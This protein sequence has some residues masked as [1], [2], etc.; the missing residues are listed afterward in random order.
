MMLFGY[1]MPVVQ[2]VG[3]AASQAG[4]GFLGSTSD[5]I[6]DGIPARRARLQWMA[7]A[8]GLGDHMRL[9]I[10]L[11][12]APVQLRIICVLGLTLPAGVRVDVDLVNG[13]AGL[14]VVA[15]LSAR[16]VRF[17]DGTVGAW[18]VFPDTVAP[19]NRVD[20]VLFND[21]SGAASIA[22]GAVFEIGEVAAMPAIDIEIERDWG[23]ERIDPTESELSR[24]SQPLS[25]GRQSYRRYEVT[26]VADA[27][28][29]VRGGGLAGGMD[30]NR[31][32]SSCGADARVIAVPRWRT[33]SG[34]V[35]PTALHA[36]ALYGTARFGRVSHLGGDYY[37]APV[38]FQEA[39]AIR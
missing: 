11:G 1:S 35:D 15:T 4:G 10:M 27:A 28:S 21:V 33:P 29:A 12:G 20:V 25:V 31:L 24:D 5:G 26:L 19:V 17:A 30:W 39:P 16:A 8:G 18:F 14:D 22:A 9:P 37:N 34:A 32:R 6:A 7:V 13:H 23:D 38:V 2:S 3:Y 36:T